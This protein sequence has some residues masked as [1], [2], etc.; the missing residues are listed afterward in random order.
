MKIEELAAYE[1]IEKHWSE[2]LHSECFLV[3]H[4][5]THARIVLVS[6]ED[7]NKVFYIG[8]RTPP[9]DSTGVAHI[10]EH[11]VL[12]GSEKYPLKDPFMEL[13][14]GSLS[15]FLNAMTYPDKTVYPVADCN[16]KDFQNLMDVYL[17]AVFHPN[18]YHEEKIFRQ[19]GWHYEMESADDSL[20][21]NGVVYNEMKGV[22]SSP[23]DIF[24]RETVS[25]L[26]PDNAYG[27]ESGGD[28]KDIPKLTYAAY[29]DFHR[30]YY[31][32]SNSYIY[33]YGNMDMA[34]KLEY[35]D[36]EYLSAYDYLEV[37]SAIRP[38]KP[39]EETH[40]VDRKYPITEN[41]DTENNTYYAY[42]TA[43][44]DNLDRNRYIAYQ[45]LDYALCSAPGAPVKE[46]LIKAGIGQDVYS[47]Y[48]NGIFQPYFSIVA[49]GAQEGQRDRFT[50]IIE[51]TLGDIVKNGI[52]RKS[53]EAALNY[54]EFR[55]R[56]ADF[57]SFPKGLIWG[58]GMLDSW[59]YDDSRPFIHAEELATFAE[60]R[61]KVP[62][63]YFEQLIKE[64][65]LENRH[66][67]IFT[68]SPEKG[69]NVKAEEEE[70]QRLTDIR[71]SM[72]IEERQRTADETK[73]LKEYQEE[74]EKPENIAKIPLLGRA[75]LKKNAEPYVNEMCSSDGIDILC[76]P[77]FTNGIGYLNLLFD[78][79][80]VPER[81]VPY[82]AVL[83]SFIGLMDTERY[84]YGELFNE[85]N[86]HTGGITTD[87]AVYTDLR[88]G[89]SFR[90]MF[91]VKA[92]V[93]YDELPAAFGLIREMTE[94][95]KWRD[96]GRLKELIAE[97]KS[98]KESELLS[99]GHIT[100]SRRALSYGSASSMYM[101]QMNGIAYYRLLEKLEKDYDGEKEKLAEA[102]EE[103]CSLI[104]CR[105][106]LMADYTAEEG[107]F[108]QVRDLTSEYA[109]TLFKGRP[110]E[111]PY[112]PVPEMKNE[113]FKTAAK[114]QYVC[115]AGNFRDKGLEYTGALSV[116]RTIISL[117]Y[118]WNQVRV[119]GGAYGCMCDFRRNGDCYFV[120]YRDPN[121]ERT[122]DVYE[123]A[124]DNISAFDADERTMTKF[125]I[126]TL[127][128]IDNPMTPAEKGA[129]SL[130]AYM[131]HYTYD[132][133]QKERD[134]IL[135]AQPE[136]IRKTADHIRA[137]MED[138]CLCVVGSEQQID[139]NSNSF[140]KTDFLFK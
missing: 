116:L 118:L 56:E 71:D 64:G 59:L 109:G 72:S 27:V 91:E 41:E 37:D 21:I 30:K 101:D 40:F 138:G 113:G 46:A 19:E 38:Q 134:Q 98:Q 39:F 31:H 54:Y 124:A 107:H 43:M 15:T 66:K 110:Q 132:R 11:T 96:Y 115:R 87:T 103:L 42:S 48:D 68:F 33:L 22:Y 131:T 63:G 5:K 95:T 90:M 45:V 61:K 36:R 34:E 24:E 121:L 94:K 122:I 62:E 7:D 117:E 69:L 82:A 137:F 79:K 2:D 126:G 108:E 49:H 106:N 75:D 139:K 29:L 26:F 120:S 3:R 73:A 99:A 17:D 58:L 50:G 135:M 89:S 86:I 129:Y 133:M 123:K 6:N 80:N 127:S 81:L 65:I 51:K 70:K 23:D 55:Y 112:I 102:L 92:R 140:V 12:C 35:L 32:P 76:H 119:L 10:I 111:K 60:L 14:K 28:P 105:E 74:P 25:S 88:D 93:L 67:S 13:E 53:L 100:A 84:T 83:K 136:D 52:N 16:D 9:T 130:S 128:R 47:I 97:I 8:F 85:I 44:H 18:I 77:I 114:I 78:M 125:I 1:I 20:S 104:F 57:G 4:K